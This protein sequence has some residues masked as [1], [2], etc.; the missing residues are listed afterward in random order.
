[1][2]KIAIKTS[3]FAQPSIIT[4]LYL[5]IYFRERLTR[6]LRDAGGRSQSIYLT[7][8]MRSFSCKKKADYITMTIL[9]KLTTLVKHKTHSREYDFYPMTPDELPPVSREE[10]ELR[11]L[12]EYDSRFRDHFHLYLAVTRRDQ[13]ISL[14]DEIQRYNFAD[15]SLKKLIVP[16]IYD[17]FLKSNATFPVD[18]D[19]DINQIVALGHAVK[20]GTIPHKA[21]Q[22]VESATIRK[23]VDIHSEF[24]RSPRY[25]NFKNKHAL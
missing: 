1:M 18:L 19:L 13:Y 9:S 2:E 3:K 8:R 20:F 25:H 23:L 21:M 6:D 4:V 12:L 15:S 5:V 14:H 16:T 11:E 24:Q 17:L 7:H 22:M 10:I